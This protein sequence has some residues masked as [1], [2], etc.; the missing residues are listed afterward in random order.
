MKVCCECWKEFEE[1]DS[2]RRFEDFCSSYC[3][4][5]HDVNLAEYLE[6]EAKEKRYLKKMEMR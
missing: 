5:Q 6:D 3:E 4:T 2:H 1:S